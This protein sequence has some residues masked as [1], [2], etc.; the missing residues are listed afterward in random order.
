MRYLPGIHGWR[1][2]ESWRDTSAPTSSS[3]AMNS[4]GQRGIAGLNCANRSKAHAVTTPKPRTASPLP[5]TKL[6][7]TLDD[8]EAARARVSGAIVDTD[9]DWSRTLSEIL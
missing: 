6:P 3:R 1:S 2:P 4:P 7:V 9:C 5:D 8:V